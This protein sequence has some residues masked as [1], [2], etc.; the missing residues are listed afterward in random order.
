MMKQI[1]IREAITEADVA[2]F[3]EQLYAHFRRDIFPDPTVR[4]SITFWVRNTG[5][6]SKSSTT[7]P[8]IGAITCSSIGTDRTSVL[9]CL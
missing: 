8:K 1:T 2:V 6:V 9:P 7:A 4:I 5:Q 3:W